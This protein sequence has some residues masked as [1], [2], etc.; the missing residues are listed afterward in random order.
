[1]NKYETAL[2]VLIEFLKDDSVP[3]GGKLSTSFLKDWIG[4]KAKD[5]LKE[6]K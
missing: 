3:N 4:A 5:N 1:M 6:K 2:D